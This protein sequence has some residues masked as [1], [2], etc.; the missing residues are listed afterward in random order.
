MVVR[1]KPNL[2]LS[3]IDLWASCSLMFVHKLQKVWLYDVDEDCKT[4]C[5]WYS[6]YLKLVSY[7][8][9]R[10]STLCT[11]ACHDATPSHHPKMSGWIPT[12][13][14]WY[15]SSWVPSRQD[16]TPAS[17]CDC[18]I[19]NPMVWVLGKWLPSSSSA[20]VTLLTYKSSKQERELSLHFSSGCT[21]RKY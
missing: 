18:V 16:A 12:K 13:L 10:L 6:L 21:I 8:T 3:G 17:P 2:V 7:V 5:K 9:G 1:H 15:S 11:G 14:P 19:D 4:S 20:R